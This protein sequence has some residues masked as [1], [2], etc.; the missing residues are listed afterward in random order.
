MMPACFYCSA[1]VLPGPVGD[2]G[3]TARRLRACEWFKEAREA[4]HCATADC[5]GVQDAFDYARGAQGGGQGIALTTPLHNGLDELASAWERMASKEE[6]RSTFH[7]S[8]AYLS[9]L[10]KR[11]KERSPVTERHVGILVDLLLPLS[12]HGEEATSR[13]AATSTRRKRGQS[14]VEK[15]EEAH[16]RSAKRRRVKGNVK[17]EEARTLAT[18]REGDGKALNDSVQRLAKSAATLT[19]P[20][21]WVRAQVVGP[22]KEKDKAK[23]EAIVA[24]LKSA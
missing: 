7:A 24:S 5:G 17:E 4:A 9:R 6:L 19:F 22:S 16:G 14:R 15:E 12:G 18:L 8:F 23:V 20:S 13:A 1:A 10:Y 21:A 11:G 3:D 2:C